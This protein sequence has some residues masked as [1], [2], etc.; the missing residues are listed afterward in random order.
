MDK[1][2]TKP[3]TPFDELTVS[4]ELQIMKLLLPYTPPSNQ[5]MLGILIKFLELQHTIVFFQNHTLKMQSRTGSGNPPSFTD[6]LEE[7]AP[8]LAPDGSQIV[9]QFREMADMMNLMNGVLSPEQQEMFQM[10]QSMFAQEGGGTNGRM[11]E[12]SASEKYGSDEIRADS[13]GS[14]PNIGKE[15]KGTAP[16]NDDPDYKCE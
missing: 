1:K 14:I 4:P 7:I 3:V 2:Q 15:R 13:N 8:Y 11:D 6:M 9:N 10:Y 5:Q 12:Q 16:G